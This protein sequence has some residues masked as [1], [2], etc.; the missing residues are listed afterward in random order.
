MPTRPA[1]VLI[2]ISL[3]LTFS[4]PSFA[5]DEVGH[6]I[7][8]YIAWDRMTPAAREAVVRLM[9][10]GPEDSGLPSYY[11]GY[12][13]QNEDTR[14]RDY[15]VLMA[16]WA[17]FIKDRNLK[18][19]NSKYSVPNWHYTDTYWMEK[20][21]KPVLVTLNEPGGLAIQKIEEFAK[22]IRS[23]TSKDAE[24]AIAIAWL[25]HLIGDIHQPLHAS[26]RVTAEFP[27]GDQ[28]GNTFLLTPTGTPR[29]QQVNL[30]SYWDSIVEN[31]E[32]NS[33]N[34]CDAD[35][36]Y[37]VAHDIMEK[38]P[39]DK[40]RDRMKDDQF[41][42]WMNESFSLATTEVYKGVEEGKM[43]SKKYTE[44][45]YKIAQER[46]A[47]G[48]YRLGDLFNEVFGGTPTK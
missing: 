35:Y 45:A 17:D 48:G 7:T 40:L 13:S 33:R 6:K 15:F 2:L 1:R 16:T 27:K 37:P 3:V 14:K 42:A 22:I 34:L 44:N 30:H 41:E 25:I 39:Y 38:F 47:L 18:T 19:R 21:G 4:I 26:S 12:G 8:A 31:K 24:K 46:F 23:P 11:M 28:G 20:D 10:T 36:I 9:L 5:W 29:E 43:P 32:A